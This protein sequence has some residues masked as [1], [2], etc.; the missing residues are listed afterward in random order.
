MVSVELIIIKALEINARIGVSEDERGDSQRLQVDV[1]LAPLT[2]FSR[3]GDDLNN[4]VD[5]HAVARRIANV[6]A[7]RPRRLLET[8]ARE[9]VE[10]LLAEFPA[11]SAE[12]EIR[13][14]ILPAT[15]H[16]AVRY[17]ADRA[18]Q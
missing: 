13:K 10:T 2:P 3:L 16:V 5:Y 15:E 14:F 9:I 6:A 4:T 11:R 1:L 17:A 18:V 7:S 12:I 8:L